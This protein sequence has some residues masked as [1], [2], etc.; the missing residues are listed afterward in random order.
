MEF[1]N[2]TDFALK[3]KEI[4]T[5]E[6]STPSTIWDILK[7]RPKV[8][9]HSVLSRKRKWT[10]ESEDETYEPK[11]KCKSKISKH[12]KHYRVILNTSNLNL[13]N[14]DLG[15]SNN[16]ANVKKNVVT[17]TP[18]TLQEIPNNIVK[19]LLF[20]AF[21]PLKKSIEFHLKKRGSQNSNK[22]H[23]QRMIHISL[24]PIF[25]LFW[26]MMSAHH[27][28]QLWPSLKNTQPM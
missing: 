16:L 10:S 9:S 1:I 17:F 18:K 19:T 28:Y 12:K 26:K 20:G 3:R 21:C 24:D 8:L 5:S 25:A 6:N 13:N 2:F 7:H 22:F 14:N 11:P 15:N 23:G 27:W 4:S